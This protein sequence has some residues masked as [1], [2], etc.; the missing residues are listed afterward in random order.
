MGGEQSKGRGDPEPKSVAPKGGARLH[1]QGKVS[2]ADKP[3]GVANGN[4]HARFEAEA[5]SKKEA[6]IAGED[7]GKVG[8]DILVQPR[9]ITAS[10]VHGAADPDGRES[11][12]A[13]QVQS[14]VVDRFVSLYVEEWESD[15]ATVKIHAKTLSDGVRSTVRDIA[16]A[17]GLAAEFKGNT[18]LV[19][20]PKDAAHARKT[21]ADDRLVKAQ[22]RLSQT[23][24]T[25][26]DED[27]EKDV[28]WQL[29]EAVEQFLASDKLKETIVGTGFLLTSEVVHGLLKQVAKVRGVPLSGWSFI[30][31]PKEVTPERVDT[32]ES[33]T[34]SVAPAEADGNNEEAKLSPRVIPEGELV[35]RRLQHWCTNV[36]KEKKFNIWAR[37]LDERIKQ[38]IIDIA[39]EVG[40]EAATIQPN[41]NIHVE[42]K[43]PADKNRKRLR[44]PSP[45]VVEELIPVDKAVTEN[46][47]AHMQE[48]IAEFAK[49]R[50]P[51]DTLNCRFAL[52]ADWIRKTATELAEASNLK[53]VQET[54]IEL[55]FSRS[56]LTEEQIEEILRKQKEEPKPVPTPTRSPRDTRMSPRNQAR[57]SPRNPIRGRSNRGARSDRGRGRGRWEF[58]STT[59]PPNLAQYPA[60]RTMQ[61]GLGHPPGAAPMTR[62][63]AQ[64]PGPMTHHAPAMQAQSW[65]RPISFHAPQHY[66]AFMQGSHS[67]GGGGSMGGG[68]FGGHNPY[69]MQHH[70]HNVSRGGSHSSR[71]YN[72]GYG[73]Y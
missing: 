57:M 37:N 11:A 3:G 39:M 68:P 1:G 23:E 65:Q 71:S 20:K 17:V 59:P 31:S 42:I 40:F 69:G 18:L 6:P 8:T 41:G 62:A 70:H 33:A 5:K 73:H 61:P 34:K 16:H 29:N 32:D 72:D 53:V 50:K 9:G 49:S 14:A 25:Q 22:S 21:A 30:G 44:R 10:A 52:P 26:L 64:G 60:R 47:A 43:P 56:D 38:K 66:A 55:I 24:L 36:R 13:A 45:E 19:E 67:Y 54:G 63:P 48:W 28:L 4:A 51:R 27:V 15:V 46:A 35:W 12:A 7:A 2:D 58:R